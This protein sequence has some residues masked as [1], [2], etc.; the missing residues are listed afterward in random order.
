VWSQDALRRARSLLARDRLSTSITSPAGDHEH[1]L[2]ELAGL[3]ADVWGGGDPVSCVRAL[4][5]EW[6]AR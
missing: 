4:R 6:P 1:S 2:L 3:G 5:D